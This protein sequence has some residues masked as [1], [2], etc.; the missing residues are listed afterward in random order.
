[1]Q[2][3][4]EA[5]DL[6]VPEPVALDVWDF[7]ENGRPPLHEFRYDGS[8]TDRVMLALN[9][10]M[11]GQGVGKIEIGGDVLAQYVK[12]P[13]VTVVYDERA[14]EYWVMRPEKWSEI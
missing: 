1:M 12:G 3:I 4:E 6:D 14:G 7:L 11:H 5:Y 13:E 8:Y 10:I 2:S 9:E